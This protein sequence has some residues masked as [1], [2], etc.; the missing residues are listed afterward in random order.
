VAITSLSRQACQILAAHPRLEV[1]SVFRSSVNLRAGRHLITCTA[2]AVQAPHGVEVAPADLA[3]LNRLGQA[4]PSAELRWHAPTR[5]LTSKS[6]DLVV[7]AVARPRVFD[8]AIPLVSTD[9]V[10]G[11]LEPLTDLLARDRPATGLGDQWLALTADARLTRAV[12]SILGYTVDE[13][14]LH[15][16]GRGPGLTP[17][18]DDILVGMIAALWCVGAVTA[19]PL[20]RMGARLEVAARRRTTDISLE[21]LH[22]ACRGM[23]AGVLRDLL[24][25]LGSADSPA[26]LAAVGRLRR[27][28]HTSGMDCLLGAVT[29]LRE[30]NR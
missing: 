18:G 1:H 16:I 30:L 21:Y 29:A 3:G 20:G 8:P 27:Y 22:Y 23:A 10:R 28:G 24:S 11:Q 25:A 7:S 17:S 13:S 12:G 6:G 4:R 19:H 5:T 9:A 2:D 26:V 15:W 14:L